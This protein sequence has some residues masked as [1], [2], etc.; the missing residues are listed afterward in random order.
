MA[1]IIENIHGRRLIRLTTDDVISLVKEYQNI[2]IETSSYE[3]LRKKL[4]T[5]NFYLPEDL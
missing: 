2:F 4:D 1:T 3:E 5:Q